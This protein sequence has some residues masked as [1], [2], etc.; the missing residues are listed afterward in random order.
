MSRID[1]LIFVYMSDHI[2][3]SHNKSLVLYHL[4]CPIKYSRNVLTESV[5][6]TFKNI[7]LEIEE[8]YEI[9]FLRSVYMR[10]MLIF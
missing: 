6:K 3:K 7:F 2:H 4:V 1:I 9:S 5:S 8:R 10:I